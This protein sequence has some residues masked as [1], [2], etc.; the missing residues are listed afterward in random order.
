MTNVKG[1]WLMKNKTKAPQRKSIAH[2]ERF[3]FD[4]IQVHLLIVR[5]Y[6][7]HSKYYIH[8][9]LRMQVKSK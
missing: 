5:D 6:Y 2:S 9:N 1:Y 4:K 7:V 3:V 8:S